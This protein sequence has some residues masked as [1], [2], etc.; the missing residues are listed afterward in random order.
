MRCWPA[1]SPHKAFS[2]GDIGQFD[3]LM[4]A[5]TRANLADNP[6]AA[7]TAFRAALALQQKALGKDNPNTATAMMSLALQL[8]NEGRYAEA[9]AMF[10]DA[11]KLVPASG[12]CH[13]TGAA[14]ALSRPGRVEPGPA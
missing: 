7:E 1:G 5:G 12:G 10:A 11:G 2:S 14:A 4:S 3:G 8:S 6:G 13:R 9:D